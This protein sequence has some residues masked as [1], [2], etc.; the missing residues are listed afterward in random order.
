MSSKI[1]F[2]ALFG[3]DSASFTTLSPLWQ[4][5]QPPPSTTTTTSLHHHHDR[6][7]RTTAYTLAAV[8]TDLVKT[9]MVLKLYIKKR[10]E[11]QTKLD[12]SPENKKEAERK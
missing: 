6:Y 8:Q 11:L 2:G 4:T 7:S 5:T 3:Q 9:G 12:N 10:D 1:L